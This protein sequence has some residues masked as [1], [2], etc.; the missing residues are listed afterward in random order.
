MGLSQT[1][2]TVFITGVSSGLGQALAQQHLKAGATVYGCS[3][4]APEG[5][6]DCEN[7][8][9][10]ALDL[11]DAANGSDALQN[12][13]PKSCLLDLVYLNAG[14]FGEV[15]PALQTPLH[16]FKNVM[17]VNVWANHWILRG[18]YERC[19]QVHQVV[20]ISSGA[21]VNAYSGWGAYNV[22]KAALNM[23]IA[24]VAKENPQSHFTALAPGL[25][26]TGMQDYLTSLSDDPGNGP[27]AR[28]KEAKQSGAMLT[29]EAAACA[30]IDWLP[31]LKEMPSGSFADLRKKA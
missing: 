19:H 17:E 10:F 31:S 8:H 1:Y 27:I 16:T 26:D 5:I 29:P 7:F 21:S 3:R 28:L 24:I 11:S 12:V 20:A 6:G 25:V 18:L 22:S 2:K 15:C 9:Y 4:H 23:F 13:F 30:I 14:I